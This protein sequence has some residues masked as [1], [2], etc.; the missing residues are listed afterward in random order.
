MIFIQPSAFPLPT[1]CILPTLYGNMSV[2]CC[3]SSFSHITRVACG[4]A[5]PCTHKHTQQSYV[6]M[7]FFSCSRQGTPAMESESCAFRCLLN[8]FRESFLQ[9]GL[10]AARP[11]ST[12]VAWPPS[13]VI[14]GIA[15]LSA[16]ALAWMPS[17]KLSM[18]LQV[19]TSG[20]TTISIFEQ[21]GTWID[22]TYPGCNLASH[23]STASRLFSLQFGARCSLAKL[24]L[25]RSCMLWRSVRGGLKTSNWEPRSRV[26]SLMRPKGDGIL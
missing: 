11:S 5:H 22:S 1:L 8:Y 25:G 19:K 20:F 6:F 17:W 2:R 21:A 23:L 13:Y 10:Q 24:A 14:P 7:T 18:A 4:F 26:L 9:P 15:R 3:F 16:A 12:C